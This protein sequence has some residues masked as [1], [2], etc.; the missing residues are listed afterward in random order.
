MHLEVASGTYLGE[1]AIDVLVA[2]FPVAILAIAE[3]ALDYRDVSD[4]RHR[5]Q[6]ML[7]S[8]TVS[9]TLCRAARPA[10]AIARG[11]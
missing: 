10:A 9:W 7:G 6:S 2:P 1:L 3:G 11:R 4:G 5:R 8:G